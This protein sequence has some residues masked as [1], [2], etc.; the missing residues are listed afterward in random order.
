M[1]KAVKFKSKQLE[2]PFI[3]EEAALERL[4]EF[5]RFFHKK[6]KTFIGYPCNGAFDLEKFFE[7]WQQSDIS[8]TP[9]NEVGNPYS[10]TSYSL[11]ARPFEKEVLHFFA[12][13]FSLQPH[14]GYITSGGTQGNEQ[15]LYMGR[16]ALSK[17]G[18]PLLYVSEEA[19]Y[20]IVSLGHVLGIETCIVKSQASG[21]M[22][23]E[24]LQEK[25][26]V[27]RPALFSLSIGT[28]FKGAIDDIE[29]IRSV[30]EGKRLER[31]FY[32]ADAALF[33]G[34]LPF[35]RSPGKPELDFSKFPYDSIAVSGHKFFGSP[36]PLGIFLIRQEHM[37]ALEGEYIEYIHTHNLTIPCSRSA[38]NTLIFW[39][40]LATVPKEDFQ[41]QAQQIVGNA[42]YLY[43]Q[44]RLRNYPVWLNP[45]SNTVYFKAPSPEICSR[46][47]L[48]LFTCKRLGPLAH[49]IIMQHVTRD[50]I[51][52]F[53]RDFD[54]ERYSKRYLKER[55]AA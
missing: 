32:H 38:L 13:L 10:E 21:E 2:E 8:K 1:K 31:V 34:Y 18:E 40:T 54:R 55:K 12:S 11:N 16:Q 27:A 25:L 46:W 45:Y 14:W 5:D 28:T 43:Q 49:A 30:V 53:L 42:H 47:T 4:E 7:W 24:D 29:R 52:E 19:H 44:L 36:T 41:R 9:L 23:Y 17:F 39:W 50:K 26:V 33:G 6:R 51:N 20:S 3:G 48:S 22:D 37:S 15:G 35:L